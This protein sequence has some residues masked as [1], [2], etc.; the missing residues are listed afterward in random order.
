[1]ASTTSSKKASGSTAT[2]TIKETRRK[3]LGFK[4]VTS[5]T[6]VTLYMSERKADYPASKGMLEK[7]QLTFLTY[8]EALSIL[9]KDDK[10]K[11]SLKDKWFYLAGKGMNKKLD[12]YKI[13][14]KGELVKKA[15]STPVEMTV[16]V[17]NGENPL[18]LL[19]LSG[20]GASFYGRRFNLY[21]YF[22]PDGV[23]P[24]V[25]G[26]AKQPA[27][28]VDVLLRKIEEAADNLG[29]K[30]TELERLLRPT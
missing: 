21:A 17:W 3:L 26:R 13:N 7:A 8:Q 22:E 24:V 25:V 28:A 5:S 27:E 19:V 14:K 12:L 18:S 20:G 2:A 6:G 9:T 30:I 10:L 15:E 23:A 11:E 29:A 16:R 1:M 4:E